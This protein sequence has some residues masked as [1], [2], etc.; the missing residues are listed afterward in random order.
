MAGTIAA[1]AALSRA[2]SAADGPRHNE[3]TLAGLRPGRSKLSTKEKFPGLGTA[4]ADATG[5]RWTD[6][7]NGRRLSVEI[8]ED[9]TVR[10]VTISAPGTARTDCASQQTRTQASLKTGHGLGLGDSCERATELYGKPESRGPSVRGT[11]KLELLFYSFDW[12]GEDVPQSMEVSCDP[13]SG[14]V[15][16]ITLASSTL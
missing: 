15:V 4:T 6:R 14:R 10:T 16:E 7:C 13:A 5:Y 11:R 8:E 9:R 2:Q 1:A 3:S 12:A